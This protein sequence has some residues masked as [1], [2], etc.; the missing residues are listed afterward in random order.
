M[1]NEAVSGER[2]RAER[3]RKL[4]CPSRSAS[5]LL[6]SA[7]LAA[8][9]QLA[10]LQYRLMPP[11]SLHW[12]PLPC[13]P[14][15][16]HLTNVALTRLVRP[17]CTYLS[18]ERSLHILPVSSL[19]PTMPP[20]QKRDFSASH[21]HNNNNAIMNE[22]EEEWYDSLKANDR[23]SLGI[24]GASNARKSFK[25][26]PLH[27]SILQYIEQIGVGIPQ[28]RDHRHR[29]RSKQGRNHTKR[30]RARDDASMQHLRRSF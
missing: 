2:A 15:A 23:S 6:P 18:T 8:P 11:R 10:M 29:Q 22:D 13:A 17:R 9:Y 16:R 30:G 3:P 26:V 21:Q 5:C 7:A 27:P 25:E 14:M 4:V 28:R 12:P 20:L 1:K 24:S 19:S